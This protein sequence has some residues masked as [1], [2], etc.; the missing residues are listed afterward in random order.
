MNR[1]HTLDSSRD[2]RL[3]AASF[4]VFLLLMLGVLLPFWMEYKSLSSPAPSR[5]APGTRSRSYD[6]RKLYFCPACGAEVS[7][8][9]WS[10]EAV[11]RREPPLLTLRAFATSTW[12]LSWTSTGTAVTAERLR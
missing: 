3:R 10:A 2:L 5:A 12:E 11:P 8:P 9:L 6:S 1:R 4:F 7:L